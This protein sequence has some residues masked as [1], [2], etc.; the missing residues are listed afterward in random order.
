[1][2]ADCFFL[3]SAIGWKDHSVA[4]PEERSVAKPNGSKKGPPR[5]PVRYIPCEAEPG[6]F[7]DE[8]LVYLSALAPDQP[9]DKIRVQMLVDQ[10]EIKNLKGQPKR[11]NP[12]PGWLRV[13]LAGEREGIAEVVLPQP[14]QPVGES[15]LVD[16]KELR[17]EA[18]V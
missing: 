17:E 6:M 15:M 8:L 5:S 14:A 7:R 1:L 18:G 16:A 11:N 12:A 13:T 3:C 9:G 4:F 10:S 2:F